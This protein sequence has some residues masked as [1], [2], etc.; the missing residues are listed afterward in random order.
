MGS[1]N[2]WQR[3][4]VCRK[5]RRTEKSFLVFHRR[6]SKAIKAM[7]PCEGSGERGYPLASEI[8]LQVE[9]TV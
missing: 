4:P 3:C 2:T 1:W 8:E 9:D 7:K 5:T 6:Y